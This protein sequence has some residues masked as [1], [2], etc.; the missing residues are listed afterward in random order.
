MYSLYFWSHPK[1]FPDWTGETRN[2]KRGSAPH[3]WDTRAG[4]EP[5]AAFGW[6]LWTLNGRGEPAGHKGHR[7]VID[8]SSVLY[9]QRAFNNTRMSNYGKSWGQYEPLYHFQPS[10]SLFIQEI[11]I[12][13]WVSHVS[14]ICCVGKG[15]FSLHLSVRV[16]KCLLSEVQAATSLCFCNRRTVQRL[17]RI[18]WS[19]QIQK[20]LWLS[21]GRMFSL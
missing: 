21:E 14:Q 2:S 13:L 4:E 3:K 12:W 19:R 17:N 18:Y 5:A 16:V 9:L 7:F 6:S 11:S 20:G 15:S 10:P 8:Y 1:Q